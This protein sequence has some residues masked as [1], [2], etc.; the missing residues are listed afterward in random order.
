MIPSAA[1]VRRG[2]GS[3]AGPRLSQYR[4]SLMAGEWERQKAQRDLDAKMAQLDELLA[5]SI[6]A[7]LLDG[8]DLGPVRH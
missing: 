8:Y 6:G 3:V 1:S 2:L 5:A 7:V 4:A